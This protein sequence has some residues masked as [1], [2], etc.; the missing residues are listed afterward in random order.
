MKKRIQT[1]MLIKHH[2]NVDCSYLQDNWLVTAKA[3]EEALINSGA[4]PN[5]DYT[6]LDL[7]KLAQPFVLHE[8][9]EGNLKV[10][11]HEKI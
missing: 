4:K 11:S 9:K 7:Y 1:D 2:P 10:F 6:Y 8:F 3:I 5:I